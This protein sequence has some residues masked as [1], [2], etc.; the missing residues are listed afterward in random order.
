M[1]IFDSNVDGI[2]SAS[3]SNHCTTAFPF[4]EENS[5]KFILID[6]PFH[7]LELM[8]EVATKLPKK[9]FEVICSSLKQ[10]RLYK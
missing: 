1:K 4:G 6:V 7:L 10:Y 8:Y 3:V 2:Y 9:Q 5:H